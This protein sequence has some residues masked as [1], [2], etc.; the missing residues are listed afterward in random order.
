MEKRTKKANFSQKKHK[1]ERVLNYIMELKADPD[2][3][4]DESERIV[5]QINSE[6]KT[7]ANNNLN[8]LLE[9][10][11]AVLNVVEDEGLNRHKI[12]TNTPFTYYPDYSNEEFN[13]LIYKKKEFYLHRGEKINIDDELELE[14]TSKKMCDPLFD[15]IT[16]S[17]ISDKSRVMFNLTN[18]QKFLKTFMSPQTPYNSL[19]VYHGTGVGKTCTSISIA[20]QYI[21][22]LSKAGKKVII[23]LNQSIK[24]NFIKNIFN[25]QK[26][27]SD[28]PYYQCTG[29][30]YLK[31]IPNYRTMSPE[32][33]QKKI[34]KLIK[35]RYEFYGYQKFAN[36]INMMESKIKERFNE[37]M[38]PKIFEKKIKEMFSNNVMIIDEAHNIK[39]GDTLKVLPPILEKVIKIADNM[40]LLLLTA[41]PMF[42]NATEIIWLVNLLLMNQK[43]PI[44]KIDDYFEDGRII[45]D[46]IPQFKQKIQG[47][48][49]Y[50]RGE[51][52]M[53]FPS[54]IYPKG[55]GILT[56]DKMP[57][58]TID[59]EDIPDEDQIKELVLVDCPM[60]GL[61]NEVYNNMISSDT[62][63]G[64]FKQPG[65]M[66]SNIV[67]PLKSLVKKDRRRTKSSGSNAEVGSNENSNNNKSSEEFALVDYIGD[68]GFN[69]VAKK[70]KDGERVIYT[71][72]PRNNIFLEEN[73]QNYS[74]KISRL[75]EN[76]K[77]SEG[78]V[79]I[80]SQFINSGVVPV[81]LALE[82]AGYSKY[83]GS[84][85]KKEMR[86]NKG[87]YI[88]ISGSNDLSKHAYRNY[89]KVENENRDGKR[90]KIIIGSETASEGL[91]FRFIRSVHILEPWFHLNKIDQVVG[92]GIRNCSHIDLPAEKR[93][94]TIHYYCSTSPTTKANESLDISIYRDAE[95]K[96]RNMAE[97]EY[98]IKTSAVDCQINRHN[99]Q[100]FTDKDFSRRCNYK[101]CEF[102]CDGITS[103][104]HEDRKLN[105]DTINNQVLNDSLD[106]V[107]KIL[108]Y[109][110]NKSL[111]LFSMNNHFTLDEILQY[112]DMDLLVTLLGLNKLILSRDEL[113]DKY[114]RVCQ[115][116]YKNGLYVLIPINLDKTPF[117]SDDLRVVPYKRTKKMDIIGSKILDYLSGKAT[118]SLSDTGQIKYRVTKTMK[119]KPTTKRNNTNNARSKKLSTN[120]AEHK[121]SPKTKT[122]GD[123][124]LSSY[125][126][127]F[128]QII[129]DVMENSSLRYLEKVIETNSSKHIFEE[130]TLKDI[131]KVIPFY[132]VDHLDPNRKKILCEV[133]I[134]KNY[135]GIL[136]ADEKALM[137]SIYNIIELGDVYYKDLSFKGD[138]K[139]LWGYKLAT[140][141]KR[142]EYIRFD[143]ETESFIPSSTEERQA[144]QKSF[145]KRET[146]KGADGKLVNSEFF[147]AN[148]LIGFIELKLPQK[149]MEFKI[150]DKSTEKMDKS[151]KIKGTQVK[152]GSIC[153]NDGMKKPTVIK[154]IN[155][156]LGLQDTSSAYQGVEKRGLPNKDLLCLQL[157]VY[158]KYFDKDR[159]DKKRFF[160]NYEESLEFKLTKKK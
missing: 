117:T 132:W 78:I 107:I 145:I 25:V 48:I 8:E 56:P 60:K 96:S 131:F 90:I 52:P 55:K 80:Y 34:L 9:R 27:K 142:L 112:V 50:V 79:F 41:T 21:D 105:Y 115:L 104:L 12:P 53:R 11:E 159:K 67:F 22:E 151:G 10:Y 155:K 24:E 19:L 144:I 91:D 72:N 39:E 70:E 139:K 57:K 13:D 98:T 33:I 137:E 26:V 121:V 54:G 15:S 75:V 61:Q 106:D 138:K 7:G 108:K 51:N 97:V 140:F 16:G 2:K 44:L 109:G 28:M 45:V 128:N 35:S 111:R 1:Q 40:K 58:K 156:L 157:E 147:E 65:I 143:E 73:L 100:F 5:M 64:A 133:L 37:D 88:I 93:N 134:L 3:V 146:D 119:K 149:E 120:N 116:K 71:I 38:A 63:F 127:A 136:T 113:P 153:N 74:A 160:Y 158:F 86:P 4:L 14:T 152:T 101:K 6:R 110:N 87:K 124:L 126:T 42:D 118:I 92:R 30:S 94:V 68:S 36:M 31:H 49:S 114:G 102:T 17:K 141:E 29:E 84:L 77:A 82:H 47:L 76:I 135:R 103:E 83:G 150:R 129:R 46:K 122:G 125:E 148:N 81:A 123:H 95:K 43:R 23:I 69:N 130:E 59:G 85:L 20:E 62:Q 154:F 66:C 89:L 32:D 99:N 18:S